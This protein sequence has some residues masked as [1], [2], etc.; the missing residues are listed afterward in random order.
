M[1]KLVKTPRDIA[2]TIVDNFAD[3]MLPKEEALKEL[4]FMINQRFAQLEE[5]YKALEP[6]DEKEF[7]RWLITSRDSLK[8]ITLKGRGNLEDST[9]TKI[10]R[11]ELARDFC[12]KFGIK[13]EG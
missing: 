5:Y 7:I 4:E 10:I 1:T 12:A 3:L 8:K 2:K 13:K 9:Y 11:R 6:I